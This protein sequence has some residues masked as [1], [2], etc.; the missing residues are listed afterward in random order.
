MNWNPT[1]LNRVQNLVTY[2]DL[3]LLSVIWKWPLS[4]YL[5]FCHL[6][7]ETEL[8]EFSDGS[9]VLLKFLSL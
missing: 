2:S 1:S 8:G 4:K 7:T 9:C 5:P 3:G 6:F